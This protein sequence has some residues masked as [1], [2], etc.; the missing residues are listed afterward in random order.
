MIDKNDTISIGW[1]DSGTTDA[2]FT[3]GIVSLLMYAFEN[4]INITKKIRVNGNQIGRQRQSLFDHWADVEKTDWLLWIDSDINITPDAFKLLIDAADK[5][6][7]PVVSGV[8]FISKEN[9]ST[10]MMPMPTIFKET[11]NEF[12]IEYIHPMPQNQIIKVDLAGFGLVL[13]HKSIIEPIRQ[14]D[15]GYSL[16]AEKENIGD[17]YVGEDIVFFRKLKS[18]GIPLY[19]HTGALVKHIKRFALDENYYYL[20]WASIENGTLIRNE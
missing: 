13:M 7:A 16:F 20:Y 3:E 19:A 2:K 14:V 1:C 12:Q 9:E 6:L 18:T 17:S 15:P 4:K 11:E 8:Y 10:L 5:D